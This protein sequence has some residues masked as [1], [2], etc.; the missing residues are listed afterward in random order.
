ME[1]QPVAEGHHPD[2]A[3]VL[4]D[5]A[6]HHLRL[7]LQIFVD[8]VERIEHQ[9]AV[10][11]IDEAGGDHRIEDG[12]IRLWHKAQGPGALRPGDP[13]EAE[14]GTKDSAETGAQAGTKQVSTAH[15][16][17]PCGSGAI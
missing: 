12:C 4:D 13:R 14:R 9:E 7:R 17:S 16:D 10:I 15:L 2:L 8:A 1:F 6:R 5:M 11:A 3:A